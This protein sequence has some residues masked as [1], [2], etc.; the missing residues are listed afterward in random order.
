MFRTLLASAL[1][2]GLL[3]GVVAAALQLWLLVPVIGTAELYESGALTHFGAA[4][5]HAAGAEAHAHAAAAASGVG[6]HLGTLLFTTTSYVGFALFLVAGFALA[7]RLGLG[8]ISPRAG[9]LW[10]LGGF[11]ATQL[12]PALGLPPELP[13]ASAAPVEARQVWWIL[14]AALTIAGLVV[15][16]AGHGA[17]RWTGL[18][19]IAAPHVIAAPHPEAFAGVVPPELSALFAARVLGVGAVAW[20][21][22]GL[23]AGWLWRRPGAA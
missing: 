7:E 9:L 17:L 14:T 11:A 18:L 1:G 10:G 8:R 22:L 6:R 21:V 13:G 19:L 23:S 15:L 4:A 16:T 5:E 12:F 3:T 2:A 20:A